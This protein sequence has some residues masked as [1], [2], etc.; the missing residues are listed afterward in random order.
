MDKAKCENCKFFKPEERCN[1]GY[2]CRHAPS[3]YLGKD[4]NDAWHWPKI[5][6]YDWCGEFELGTENGG[7]E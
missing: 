6:F 7:K 5:Y 2:C 3:P 4:E 1:W